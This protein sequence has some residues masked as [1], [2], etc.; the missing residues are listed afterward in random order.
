MKHNPYNI[1]TLD[2][3]EISSWSAPSGKLIEY[4]LLKSGSAYTAP[5]DG[6]WYINKVAGIVNGYASIYSGGIGA[7][8]HA[9]GASSSV[10]VALRAYKGRGCVI[11]H[12]VTGKTNFFGFIPTKGAIADE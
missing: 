3:P 1:I 7:I 11:N 2:K 5:A 6:Y 9:P 10:V 4:T 8:S 12:T